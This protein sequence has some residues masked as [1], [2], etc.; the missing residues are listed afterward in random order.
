MNEEAKV[1]AVLQSYIYGEKGNFYLSTIYR[2]S[3]VAISPPMFHYETLGWTL[4]DD[5][6]RKDIVVQEGCGYKRGA[7]EQH[8]EIVKQL[9]ATGEYNEP[10]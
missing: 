2:Q 7:I 6:K 5:N 9:E 10:E 3:S 1:G 4:D 8:F